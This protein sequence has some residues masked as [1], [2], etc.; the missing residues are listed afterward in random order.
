MGARAGGPRARRQIGPSV[1]EESFV[2][3]VVNVVSSIFWGVVTFSI[4]VFVHEG[5]HFLAARACH[6]RVT[7]FFLGLPCRFNIHHTSKRI[8]TRFGITP[9][10]LGGYAQVCGMDPSRSEHAPAV[11]ACIHRHGSI[12]VADIARELGI[13]ED[14]AVAACAQLEDWGSV[15]PVYDA[16]KGEHEGGAYYASTYASMPRDKAGLTIYDGR[17]FDREHATAQ[18]EAWD[19]PM[20]TD[21]FF[22]QERAHVYLGMGFWR[23]AL[24]LVAGI[25]VNIVVGLLLIIVV[26][27]GIGYEVAV[28]T[29]VIGSVTEGSPA[30]ELGLEAGDTITALDGEQVSSWSDILEALDD[31]E[32]GQEVEV[33]FEHGGETV[34]GTATLDEDGLLGIGVSYEHYRAGVGEALSLGLS[35]VYETGAAVVEL[36][37]PTRTM[38]V[39]ESSTSIV[40]VSVMSAE[41]A[42][43]GASTYL[44]FISLVSFSL[45]LMNLLPIPPLDGGK[46]LI[47]VIQAIIRRELS[48]KVQ[49]ALSWIGIILFGALF[50]YLLQ[51]DITRFIL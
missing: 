7:E 33:T 8:G 41:A 32:A 28:D 40:G 2:D 45:G 38:E 13:S 36:L 9:I 14:D 16:S 6:V 21:A 50:I 15:A 44:V 1:V 5:G 25:A 31:A 49:N 24:I 20:G 12:S 23:R 19:P 34:S 27:S 30:E 22:A 39:L 18:G 35:A 48:P 4:L 11:L 43:Y 37:I 26:Y 3:A 17:A 46:L 10:L 47:E 51:A 29:N 42:S